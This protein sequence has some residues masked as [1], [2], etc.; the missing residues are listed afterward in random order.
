MSL[1]ACLLY[2][3]SLERS[4]HFQVKALWVDISLSL[5]VALIRYDWW[6]SGQFFFWK[7][8]CSVKIDCAGGLGVQSAKRTM[9]R[10]WISVDRESITSEQTW[11]RFAAPHHVLFSLVISK[12]FVFC[13]IR[14]F[15]RLNTC[16]Q[17][18]FYTRTWKRTY[19]TRTW[20][21][22][23]LKN[24][25]LLFSDWTAAHT[26]KQKCT[27]ICSC[28]LNAKTLRVSRTHGTCT[29][30][31]AARR[32]CQLFAW[33]LLSISKWHRFSLWTFS[34]VWEILK[35]LRGFVWWTNSVAADFWMYLHPGSNVV[36]AH[37]LRIRIVCS[38]R[39][40]GSAQGLCQAS[41]TIHSAKFTRYK[42][43]IQLFN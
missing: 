13:T 16:Q 41:N 30:Q 6:K 31:R 15:A 2:K 27:K 37:D 34:C 17:L 18:A 14:R 22:T 36:Q 21:F 39:N 3:L 9:V 42:K 43:R 26:V 23:R 40:R 8:S 24:Q 33:N 5:W 29:R 38:E 20:I 35:A 12:L 4:V 7:R 11:P 32:W 25:I 19:K 28:G 1:K 10:T